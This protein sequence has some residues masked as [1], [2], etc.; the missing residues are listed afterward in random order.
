MHRHSS[1][2]IAC[3]LPA[4]LLLL[5]VSGCA[6]PADD[7]GTAWPNRPIKLVVPFA[8]GGGADTLG[9]IF[10]KAIE[11]NHLLPQP[12]VIVNVGGAGATIGSRRVKNARPDGYTVLLLHDAILMSKY[13]GKVAYGPEAFEPV[14]GTAEN[15]LVIAVRDD[16]P[17]QNLDDLVDDATVRKNQ[18]TFGCNLGTPT[19]FV[20]LLLERE[21]PGAAFR[22]VQTGD[23]AERFASL[24]GDHIELTVF[25]NEEFLR[26]QPEGIRALGFFGPQRH[27]ALP[28]VPTAIEQG[29]EIETGIMHYWW[30]PKGTPPARIA[31]FAKAL[32]Q[33]MQTEEVQDWLA[34]VESDPVYMEG[35]PLKRRLERLETKIAAVDLRRPIDLPDLPGLVLAATLLLAGCVVGRAVYRRFRLASSPVEKAATVAVTEDDGPVA[36]APAPRYGLALVCIALTTAYVAA[37]GLEFHG[38]SVGFRAATA[39]YAAAISLCLA[40]FDWRRLPWI[41]GLSAVLSLGLHFLFTQ[42]FVTDLP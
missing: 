3:R 29:Y 19:H 37:L 25:S 9:R 20:G 28:D 26:Y 16:S 21:R 39:V 34:Q 5:C 36:P 18:I 14:A 42:V 17:Y 33:A 27:P 13:S 4:I 15:G 38:L 2:F 41:A 22:F 11:E 8:A 10:K 1:I 24:R 32:E 31:V 7:P 23:G 12:L 40:P 35:E 6:A 30:M